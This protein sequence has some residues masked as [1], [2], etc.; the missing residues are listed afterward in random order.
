MS[1]DL[2]EPEAAVERIKA[3]HMAVDLQCPVTVIEARRGLDFNGL[4]EFWRYRELLYFLTWRDIKVRYKQTVLGAAWAVLQ[5]LAMMVVFSL[6]FGRV[7]NVSTG[8]V[9]YP[10]FVLCGLL[11]WFFVSNSISSAAQSI[12][13]NQTLVTKIYFPR[14]IIP[15]SA[16]SAGLVDFG[17]GLGLLAPMMVYYAVAP[18][19]QLLWLP[20]LIAGLV[21]LAVGV[22]TLLSALT[23][24]YRDFRH[25]VPFMVQLW[26]FATPAI[27]L[28]SAESFGPT[29]QALLPLNPAF[30][31]IAN[32]RAAALGAEM[33]WQALSVSLAVTAVIL[34]VAFVYFRRVERSFADII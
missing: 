18:S 15:T 29:W 8:N 23:V 16:V 30:G 6:F 17:I 9:E 14:L 12:V 26:M 1:I 10:I 5:P 21:L 28:D 4:R 33:N 27:Y 7:T 31:L 2:C 20:V 22:G 25:I 24:A 19:W 3:D 13:G 34:A 11:P 32:F